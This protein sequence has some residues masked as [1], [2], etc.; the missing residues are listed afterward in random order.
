MKFPIRLA[1]T[2]TALLA[3]AG[4]VMAANAPSAGDTWAYRVINAYNGEVRGSVQY[5]VEK[6]DADRIA[7]AMS[8]D[9]VTLGLP[10]T[11]IYTAD[12]RWV[13]HTLTSHDQPVEYEF[14]QPYPAYDFPLDSGKSWSKRVQATNSANGR[15]ANVR[16]DGDVLGT[17]RVSVPAGAFDTIKIRRRIYGG[18]FDGSRSETNIVE[19]EWYAP[20]LK[21]AVRLERNS[22][23]MDQARCADEMSACTPVRGDW[24]VFEL[25]QP[26]AQK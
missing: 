7:V 2:C 17:E 10:R 12:G 9:P 11:E 15:R 8:A 3:I 1:L 20:A 26:V 16:V 25:V 21:R 4:P 18:D 24:L 13:R 23:Y 5:R 19:T 6:T 14:A 22:G